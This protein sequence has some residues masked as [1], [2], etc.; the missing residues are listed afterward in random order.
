MVLQTQLQLQL[1]LL[2]LLLLLE[3][4]P[5]LLLRLK[6]RSHRCRGKRGRSRWDGCWQGVHV[7]PR[8]RRCRGTLHRDLDELIFR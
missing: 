4:H 6:L 7:A 5:A 8:Q 3:Q 1:L 2:L